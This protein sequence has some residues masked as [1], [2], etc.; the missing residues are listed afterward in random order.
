[1]RDGVP[2][3]YFP[4]GAKGDVHVPL[5]VV[6]DID[7]GT[8]VELRLGAPMGLTG[9]V[10]VD[11]GTV[12]WRPRT[13]RRGAPVSS[14][15]WSSATAWPAPARWRRSSPAAAASSSPSRCSATSRTATTTGSCSA[16]CSPARRSDDDIFL[17]PLDWYA[18]NGIT[19]TPV[20][21]TRIDRFAE[22]RV[23]RRR[24]GHPVRRYDK[25]VVRHRWTGCHPADRRGSPTRLGSRAQAAARVFAFRTLDDTRAMLEYAATTTTAGG[26]DR[27]RP[28]RPGGGARPA[29]ATG[30]TSTSCTPAGG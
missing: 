26:G 19:C 29:A 9:T 24:P 14:A 8:V 27:R 10:V 23:L 1:M 16:T 25:L 11:L 15:W 21:V 5:R 28:A 13:D 4:I 30:S 2:M 20:R 17:N 7:G 3:R 22:G 12:E 18:E 6:E